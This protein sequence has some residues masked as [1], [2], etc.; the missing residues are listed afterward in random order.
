MADKVGVMTMKV[1]NSERPVSTWLGGSSWVPKARRTND[2]TMT[3]RVKDVIITRSAGARERTVRSRAISSVVEMFS[4]RVASFALSSR[5]RPPFSGG[6]EA[7]G[8]GRGGL[9]GAVCAQADPD[10][11]SAQAM[12]HA[13]IHN[14]PLRITS[15][16]RSRA[17]G[18]DGF[19][20]FG[21]LVGDRCEHALLAGSL[22]VAEPLA[23]RLAEFGPLGIVAPRGQA[24]AERRHL[25]RTRDFAQ[26]RE[27]LARRADH[28]NARSDL[29]EE[30]LLLR[31]QGLPGQDLDR[32][33]GAEESGAPA[34]AA[35]Q[36]Q[37]PAEQPDDGEGSDDEAADAGAGVGP[38]LQEATA[39]GRIL[40]GNGDRRG[41]GRRLV[42]RRPG[43]EGAFGAGR[44]GGRGERRRHRDRG[45]D[46]IGGG[47]LR[48]GQN[49]PRE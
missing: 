2:R 42:L 43:G 27:V 26:G 46:G 38:V 33:P 40:G 12:R 28:E 24:G 25:V 21:Q 23:E 17:P 41:P 13:P 1:R 7:A 6:R 37:R 16:S 18:A 15:A 32:A 20:D 11:S 22:L 14:P 35:E 5:E 3:I 8:A 4:G 48:R 36:Q 49:G 34:E 30:E 45:V 29:D 19:S 44:D 39:P 10:G 9:S 31:P 47:F